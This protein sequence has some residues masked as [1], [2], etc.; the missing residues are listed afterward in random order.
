MALLVAEGLLQIVN[1]IELVLEVDAAEEE[2]HDAAEADAK[3]FGA[4][5]VPLDDPR[6]A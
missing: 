4:V 6:E 1:L 2:G 5:E 3:R